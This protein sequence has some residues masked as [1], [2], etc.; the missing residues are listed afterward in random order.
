MKLFTKLSSVLG[1]IL[2]ASL[3]QLMAQPALLWNKS[4]GEAG[5]ETATCMTNDDVGN[6]YTAGFFTGTVDFNPSASIADTAFLTSTGAVNDMYITKFDASGSF[7]WVKMIS[8][9]V[10][11]QPKAM[12]IDKWNNLVFCGF[13][14]GTVDFDPSPSSSSPLTSSGGYDGFLSRIKCFDGSYDY[15]NGYSKKYG[16]TGDD[17]VTAMDMANSNQTVYIAGTYTGVADFGSSAQGTFTDTAQGQRDIFILKISGNGGSIVFP[18]Y[19]TGNNQITIEDIAFQKVPM[20]SSIYTPNFVIT[21]KFNTQI[22]FDI[23]PQYPGAGTDTVYRI[24]NSGVGGLQTHNYLAMYS[25]NMGFIYARDLGTFSKKSNLAVDKYGYAYIGGAFAGTHD[26]D[27]SSGTFNIVSNGGNDAFVAKYHNNSGNLEWAKSFGGTTDDFATVVTINEAD[28]NDR[29]VYVAGSFNSAQVDFNPSTTATELISATGYDGFI[30]K[31]GSTGDYKY[32]SSINGSADES[33]NFIGNYLNWM[34]L[35][36]DFSSSNTDF[37]LTTSNTS[38][39]SNGASDVYV[40]AYAQCDMIDKFLDVQAI[41]IQSNFYNTAYGLTAQYQ[42]LDCGNGYAPIVGE[43]NYF[44]QFANASAGSL[45]PFAVKIS[46]NGC[47]DTSF[48]EN[49][50]SVGMSEFK[51]TNSEFQ[52]YPSPAQSHVTLNSSTTGLIQ[53]YNQQGKLVLQHQQ[54]ELTEEL[55]LN[56]LTSGIYQIRF[57]T[58]NQSITKRLILN[59]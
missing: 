22:D 42:W 56:A 54:L 46:Y 30:V 57:V 8:S 50:L 34:Y 49:L 26:F 55:N 58:N 4:F 40:A 39:A 35:G 11:I 27:P 38:V 23:D 6:V 52:V 14:K 28:T 2:F 59:K 29:S 13:F 33:I 7:V 36:G 10:E 53:V 51:N 45:G 44:I 32:A 3:P 37:N 24:V 19:I 31:L 43:T 25:L 18:G 9:T 48:C 21:G 16:G 47:V 41:Y 12:K 17:Y 20:S 5:T 1:I 15:Q